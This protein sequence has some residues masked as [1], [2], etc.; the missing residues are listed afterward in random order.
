MRKALVIIGIIIIL[1][2]S[3]VTNVIAISTSNQEKNEGCNCVN[4]EGSIAIIRGRAT[5]SL[6]VPWPDALVCARKTRE[7]PESRQCYGEDPN[8]PLQGKPWTNLKGEFYMEI[9]ADYSGKTWYIQGYYY[10]S[11]K[12]CYDML[13]AGCVFEL[14]ADFRGRQ[15]PCACR[16]LSY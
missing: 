5:N 13:S 11:F 16:R 15:G 10:Q 14:M 7:G 2:G 9:E 6:G 1:F 4:T 8:D 3:V 12:W